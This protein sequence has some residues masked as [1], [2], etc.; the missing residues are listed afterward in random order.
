MTSCRVL[1]AGSRPIEAAC[2]R[3]VL[4]THLAQNLGQKSVVRAM[5]C[6]GS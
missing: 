6:S 1:S 2:I 5:T 4:N 3:V